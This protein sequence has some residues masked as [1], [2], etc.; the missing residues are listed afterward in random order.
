MAI[1]EMLKK[2]PKHWCKV[3]FRHEVKYDVVDN[4]MSECFNAT[5]LEARHRSIV[6]MTECIRKKVSIIGPFFPGFRNKLRSIHYQG[7]EMSNQTCSIF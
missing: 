6:S 1:E 5:I 7:S 3:F 4:N 2:N